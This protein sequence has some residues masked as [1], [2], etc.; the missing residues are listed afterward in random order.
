MRAL[1]GWTAGLIGSM[2]LNL[3][4]HRPWA[5]CTPNPAAAPPLRAHP[6]ASYR[7]GGGEKGEGRNLWFPRA[8]PG[9]T[10]AEPKG[11]CARDTGSPSPVPEGEERRTLG[12]SPQHL[13]LLRASP[14]ECSRA[15]GLK[16]NVQPTPA[17]SPGPPGRAEFPGEALMGAE[18]L[19]ALCPS[20]C[21]RAAF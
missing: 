17:G 20:P 14:G 5:L 7:G 8:T 21:R 13:A 16:R 6:R 2:S 10:A 3:C 12:G 11:A 9:H 19:S 15:S 18:N 4:L 1:S